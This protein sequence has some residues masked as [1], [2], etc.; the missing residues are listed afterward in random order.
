MAYWI[1]VQE[2][3]HGARTMGVDNKRYNY[4]K[5]KGKTF[6]FVIQPLLASGGAS[7]TFLGLQYLFMW[8]DHKQFANELFVN[9]ATSRWYL[10]V[11]LFIFIYIVVAITNVISWEYYKRKLK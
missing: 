10:I 4:M 7:L 1:I 3:A 8:F 6:L 11:L 2:E 5:S 9:T